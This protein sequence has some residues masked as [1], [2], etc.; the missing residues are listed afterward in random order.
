MKFSILRLLIMTGIVA[1]W[2]AEYVI[3][4][5]C[6]SGTLGKHDYVAAA[7]ASVLAPMAAVVIVGGIYAVAGEIEKVL[8]RRKEDQ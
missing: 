1:A 8:R 6:M 2:A 3:I 4:L 7:F 5:G